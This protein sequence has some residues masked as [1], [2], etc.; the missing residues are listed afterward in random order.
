[1]QDRRPAAHSLPGRLARAV[2]FDA[3][4][5]EQMAGGF[6]PQLRGKLGA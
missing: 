3:S 1:V 6:A 4:G 2:R 5:C